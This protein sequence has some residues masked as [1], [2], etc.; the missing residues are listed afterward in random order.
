M[1]IKYL[2]PKTYGQVYQKLVNGYRKVK[3]KY[4]PIHLHQIEILK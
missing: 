1:S 4:R 2:N 3:G